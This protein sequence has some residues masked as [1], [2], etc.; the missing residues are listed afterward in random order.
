M[1]GEALPPP[2]ASA[3][4]ANLPARFLDPPR[5]RLSATA[6][7]PEHE[8]VVKVGDQVPDMRDMRQDSYLGWGSGV[9]DSGMPPLP[10]LGGGGAERAR[11]GSGH[12]YKVRASDG[13]GLQ[14]YG[15]Q[16]FDHGE[17]GFWGV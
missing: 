2:S 5:L 8:E 1:R 7:L 15:W 4:D 6:V 16:T 17:I 11:R 9:G 12:Y 3:K 13:K 14:V 10:P